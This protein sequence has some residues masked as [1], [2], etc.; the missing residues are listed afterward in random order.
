MCKLARYGAISEVLPLDLVGARRLADAPALG[1]MPINFAAFEETRGTSSLS[2]SFSTGD[3]R[4]DWGLDDGRREERV[5]CRRVAAGAGENIENV[6]ARFGVGFDDFFSFSD[7]SGSVGTDFRGARV[8]TAMGVPEMSFGFDRAS[9]GGADVPQNPHA[10]PVVPRT[11]FG[12][13][14]R[15]VG[16]VDLRFSSSGGGVGN[17]PSMTC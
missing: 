16:D 3:A 4:P 9:F 7:F 15:A 8:R 1:F 11:T 2:S 10:D 17:F 5:D 14:F 6:D 12:R 13:S